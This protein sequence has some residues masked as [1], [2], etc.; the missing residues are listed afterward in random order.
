MAAAQQPAESLG[1]EDLANALARLATDRLV[2]E[3]LMWTLMMA[4]GDVP[5]A[6][7]TLR[8]RARS[9]ASTHCHPAR[10]ASESLLDT[11]FDG[12]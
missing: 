1:L 8:S 5:A 3:S 2:A 7:N 6:L 9:T 4:V 11:G 12:A 10:R